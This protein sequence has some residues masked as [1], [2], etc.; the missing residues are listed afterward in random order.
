MSRPKLLLPGVLPYHAP[1]NTPRSLFKDT[2]VLAEIEPG[3]I[4]EMRGDL[5]Q[6]FCSHAMY[7][8]AVTANQRIA[9]GVHRIIGVLTDF[10]D[11]PVKSYAFREQRMFRVVGRREN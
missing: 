10:K 4:I 1:T 6:P 11:S 5:L 7:R 3:D 8:V 2:K 9:T